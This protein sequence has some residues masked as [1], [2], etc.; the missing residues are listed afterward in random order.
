MA[1]SRSALASSPV[2]RRSNFS[3][4]ILKTFGRD[5]R[6]RL[7]AD[8]DALDAQASS[9]SSTAT[10]FCS[11]QETTSVS[12]RSLTVQSKAS[13]SADGHL[14][15]AVG[16]VALAHVQQPRQ[17]EQLAVVVV[18]DAVLAAAEGEDERVGGRG[19]G[20]VAEVV[21]ARLG[22]VAAADEEEAADLARP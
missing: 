17:A 16:V 12:G 19:L 9:V 22:A 11:N 2:S 6:R 1:S 14:D 5:E 21:A 10:A 20:V 15:R 8:R 13:A 3:W 18:A 7:G 4:R